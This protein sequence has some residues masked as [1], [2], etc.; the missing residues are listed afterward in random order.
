MKRNRFK[1]F[2]VQREVLRVFSEHKI[3]SPKSPNENSFVKKW[4][5]WKGLATNRGVIY[6]CFFLVSINIRL[7]YLFLKLCA[8]LCLC[9]ISSKKERAHNIIIRKNAVYL[10]NHLCCPFME[11]ISCILPQMRSL[12]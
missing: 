8:R 5:Q 4:E 12:V 3:F 9:I 1:C 2:L 11:D 7:L 10:E 6:G